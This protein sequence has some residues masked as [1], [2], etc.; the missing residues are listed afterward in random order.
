MAVNQEY[1]KSI[2]NDTKTLFQG[3]TFNAGT[4]ITL[5]VRAMELVEKIPRLT[6][7]EKKVIVIEVVKLMVDE[8]DLSEEDNAKIDVII[9]TTLPIAIDLIVA[10]SRGMLNIN[11]LK[12][13]LK[14]L[15]CC[16]K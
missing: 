9:D 13:K 7:A 6:G 5:A 8:T 11:G 2:F 12:D 14:K 3:E 15:C 1:V 4:V 10:A 16:C